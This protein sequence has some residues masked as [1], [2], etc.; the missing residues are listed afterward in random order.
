M[1]RRR[2]H[3]GHGR[4]RRMRGRGKVMD[5]LRKAGNFLK[6]NKIVSRVANGLA[7]VLPPQY[8]GI[9]KSVG[10]AA[11]SIGYGR[12]RRRHHRM[13]GHGLRLAGM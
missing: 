13:R 5:F 10:T 2:T 7:S 8:A 11:G 9:A 12:H 1:Y 3:K 6:K 4:H